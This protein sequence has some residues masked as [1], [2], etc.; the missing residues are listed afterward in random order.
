AEGIVIAPATSAAQIA[1]VRAL[2]SEYAKSVGVS[3]CF[4][5]FEQELAG[6]P[7]MYAP[8]NGSLLLATVNGQSAGCCGL[9]RVEDNICEL[10]RL[11]VRPHFRNAGLGSQLA[12]EIIS[13]AMIRGYEKMRL[14]TIVGTMDDAIRLYRQLG[15]YE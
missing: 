8:P 4:Q 3:L 9:R 11:Y 13:E 12:A 15:F 7:G 5:S 2:F 1:D 14:D 10:K 6:L